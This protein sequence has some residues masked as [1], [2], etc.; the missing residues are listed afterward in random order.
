MVLKRSWGVLCES[1]TEAPSLIVSAPDLHFYKFSFSSCVSPDCP[2]LDL[3]FIVNS[4][5]LVI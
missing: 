5:C 2:H 3:S 1:L 4:L